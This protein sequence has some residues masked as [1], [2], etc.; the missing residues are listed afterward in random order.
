[1]KY[2]NAILH[3]IGPVQRIR[4]SGYRVHTYAAVGLYIVRY[5]S[6]QKHSSIITF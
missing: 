2:I 4:L 3:V 1:M 5:A 6:S